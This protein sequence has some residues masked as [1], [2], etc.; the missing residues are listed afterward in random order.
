ML[1]IQDNPYDDNEITDI[2]FAIGIDGL[3]FSDSKRYF[4]LILTVKNSPLHGMPT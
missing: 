2:K 1:I 3:D 4:N